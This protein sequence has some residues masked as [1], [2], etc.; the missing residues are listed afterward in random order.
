MKEFKQMQIDCIDK[1]YNEHRGILVK[2]RRTIFGKY[3]FLIDENG[4]N[5]KVYIGRGI[6]ED[7][8][9]GSEVT[10]GEINS[11]LINIRSGICKK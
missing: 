4:K 8:K 3:I 10:V 5:A 2:K 1:H 7:T 6:Y 11:K 9:L